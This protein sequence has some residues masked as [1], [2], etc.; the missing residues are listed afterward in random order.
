M[1]SRLHREQLLSGVGGV[2][3]VDTLLQLTVWLEDCGHAAESA[4]A[5]DECPLR[6]VDG[7]GL[8]W[9]EI[10]AGMTENNFIVESAIGVFNP[11]TNGAGRITP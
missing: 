3:F 4:F 11:G 6:P 2:L 5:V 7:D 10:R 1:A 9:A 8:A